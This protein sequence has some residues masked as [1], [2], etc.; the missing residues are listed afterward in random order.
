MK[1]VQRSTTKQHEPEIIATMQIDNT[2]RFT[3][4][5]NDYDRYRQRYPAREVL[6]IL[7]QWCGL[8]RDWLVA[9]IGAGTG[10]LAEVFLENGNRVIAIEPNAEMREACQR[11]EHQGQD[12]Q[13]RGAHRQQQEPQL[14]VIDATAEAT[15]LP[16]LS[17]DIVAVGRA[18]H[19]FDKKRALAEFRRILKPEG[20]VALVSL[21][22]ARDDSPQTNAFEQLLIEHGTDY[23]YV[24]EGYRTHDKLHEFFGEAFYQTQLPGS[25]QLDWPAFHGQTMSISVAPQEGHPHFEKFQRE[26]RRFFNTYAVDGV[27]SIATTCWITAGRF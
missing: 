2:D 5:A 10:M 7:Q 14:R 26:L 15:G 12:S 1:T 21:G 17:V 6:A 22:R 25:Q 16:N 23:K 18:F 27:L 9:D 8:S 11:L 24:R 4:R 13:E 19:W 3:G 20:W